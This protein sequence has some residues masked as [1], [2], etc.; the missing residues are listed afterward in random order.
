MEVPSEGEALR[1]LEERRRVH[2]PD[3]SKRVFPSKKREVREKKERKRKRDSSSHGESATNKASVGTIMTAVPLRMRSAEEE[4]SSS[5]DKALPVSSWG[6]EKV[7]E[8]IAAPKSRGEEVYR[9]REVFP[10]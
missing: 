9:R 1:I 3:D 6:K 5:Q 2:I 8:S 10:F 7:G 4:A